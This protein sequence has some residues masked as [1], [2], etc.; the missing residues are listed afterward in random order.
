MRDM[1]KR[2]G[3]RE[4]GIGRRRR[5]YDGKKGIGMNGMVGRN[6]GE[7]WKEGIGWKRAIGR[8]RGV[9]KN[10]GVEKRRGWR[11][12]KEI[13]GWTGRRLPRKGGIEGK[14]GEELGK[15]R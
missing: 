12:R 2:R 6:G 5:V 15:R 4:G 14:K 7:G 8:N 3:G 13:R 1:K 10:E 9:G 11:N